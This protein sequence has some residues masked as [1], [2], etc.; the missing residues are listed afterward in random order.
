MFEALNAGAVTKLPEGV[1][2]RR[3]EVGVLARTAQETQFATDRM[4]RITAA[5]EVS[6]APIVVCND[7][8][9]VTYAN[10]AFSKMIEPSR[11]YFKGMGSDIDD[12]AGKNIDIFHKGK[13][14]IRQMLDGLQERHV[15]TISFDERMFDVSASPIVESGRRLGYVITWDDVTDSRRLETQLREVIAAGATSRGASTP[16][17]RT[18]S[19]ATWARG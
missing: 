1:L 18:P 6:A 16:T 19:C 13:A 5:L 7:R 2:H 10:P 8:F 17:P 4:N 15:S 9:Y 11:G 14:R 3:D 12:L